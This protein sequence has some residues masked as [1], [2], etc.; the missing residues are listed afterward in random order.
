[1]SVEAVVCQ[2]KRIYLHLTYSAVCQVCGPVSWSVTSSLVKII[3]QS[4]SQ[5]TKWMP[6]KKNYSHLVERKWGYTSIDISYIIWC[7]IHRSDPRLLPVYQD[8]QPSVVIVCGIVVT[9]CGLG[10]WMLICWR[11]IMRLAQ[12]GSYKY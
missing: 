2:S 1:M 8:I 3:Q 12:N 10:P 9:H 4:Q 7:I 11:L 6:I 5:P